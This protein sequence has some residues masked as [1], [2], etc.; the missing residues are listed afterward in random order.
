LHI[1]SEWALSLNNTE[2]G[3]G[4][5]RQNHLRDFSPSKEEAGFG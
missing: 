3:P 1:L 4:S 2:E 5:P